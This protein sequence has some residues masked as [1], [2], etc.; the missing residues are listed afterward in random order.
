MSRWKALR[1]VI[2]LAG[3]RRIGV[4]QAIPVT[5]KTTPAIASRTADRGAFIGDEGCRLA[6]DDIVFRGAGKISHVLLGIMNTIASLPDSFASITDFVASLQRAGL[7]L[8]V[9][10]WLA[11]SLERAGDHLRF[12]LDPAEIRSLLRLPSSD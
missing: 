8:T 7:S 12:G 1:T 4:W 6:R 9:S 3:H 2:L 10:Q 5:A 11:G